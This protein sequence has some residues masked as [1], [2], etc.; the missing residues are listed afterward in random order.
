MSQENKTIKISG[1]LYNLL[2]QKITQNNFKT[3][4]DYVE[5]LLLQVLQVESIDEIDPEE[6][7][8]IRQR[9]E[10]LGYL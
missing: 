5:H 4:D 1:Q 2:K 10:K 9:L 6:E 8:K 7:E 3:V